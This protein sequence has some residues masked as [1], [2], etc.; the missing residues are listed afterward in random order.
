[1]QDWDTQRTTK[2]KKGFIASI[3]QSSNVESKNGDLD[4]YSIMLNMEIAKIN[5]VLRPALYFEAKFYL[6]RVLKIWDC[7][8]AQREFKSAVHEITR[9]HDLIAL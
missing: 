3:K 7:A 9:R 2:K 1:M 6:S 4:D 5:A 8:P